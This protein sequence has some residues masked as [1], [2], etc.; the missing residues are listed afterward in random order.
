M[1]KQ[2]STD[3]PKGQIKG[4]SQQKL[5]G[6]RQNSKEVVDLRSLLIHCAQAVAADD[7]LLATDLIKK[8]RQHSSA[9]GDCTQRL[10]F[11][12][13]DGLEARLSGMGIQ[14]H[15]KLLAK[16]VSDEEVFKIYSLCLAAS[17]LLRASYCFANRT[18]IEASRGQ[19]KVHI[20]DFG[21][22]FGFQWPS[23]IQ[24]FAEQGVPPKLR[25][26]GID[27][28]RPGFSNLEITE[29]AG[30]RLADYANM[31]KVPFQYQGITS[32]YEN[33]QIEDIGIEEDEVLIVNSL[34]RMKTLGDETVAMNSARDRVLK[35]M[36]GM[37]P[38]VFI[39]GIVNGSYSSPFFITRFKELLFHYSSLFDMFDAN[40]PR[41][42]ETRKLI[43]GKLLGREAMNIIACEGAERIER[44][45]TYKQ[46]QARCLKA[47]F[48]QLPVDPDV[49]N[50]ILDMKKGI[51][52][53]DFV[54]DED[55]GWLLQGWK[56][57][58]MHAISKWKP[59]E[60]CAEQFSKAPSP[61]D[62]REYCD[63]NSN[64][65]LKYINRVLMEE[66]I[67]E[68]DIIYQEHDALQATEKPF[69]GIL[70]QAYPSSAKEMVLNNDS[71]VDCPYGS[72]NNN[73]EGACRGSFVNGFLG[74]QVMHLTANHCASETCHLSSQFTKRAEEA[75]RSSETC[76]LSSQFT[77]RAEEAN[78]SVP[79]IEKLV[80]DLDSSEVADSKQ[81]TQST[82][83]RKGKHVTQMMSHHELLDARNSNDLAIAG[84]EITRNG[85]FDN[86]LLC[87]GQ[88][89]RDAAHLRE[90]KAKERCD[91]SQ[92]NQSKGYGQGQ[93][94]K[95]A[96][97]QQEEAIDFRSLLIQCAEAI[98]ST[99]QPFDRE[100]LTKIRN[101]SSPNGDSSQRLAI[102]FVDA[103]EAR[104]AG[105][106]SQMYHKLIAKRRSAT[107]MLKAYRLCSAACPF[108]KRFA[109]REGSP[110]NLRITGIDVP[111]PGF[112]PSKKIEETGKRLAEYAE[113][114][115]I[116]FQYQ[117]VVSRW[118]NI[119]IEDLNIDKDEVL[120]INCLH[121]MKNLGDETED[122]DSAR[123][124]VLRIIKMMNP[125]VLIIGVT[126]GSY[127]SP[128]FL[129][130]FREV[131]FYYSSLFDMLNST[132]PRS[133][134]ARILIKKDI[135]GANVFNVVACEGA[136]RIEKPESY[137]KWQVRIFNAG[138][139]QLPV[140][141]TIL[142]S[143]I[144]RKELYHEDFVIDEDN[145]WLLQGWKGRVIHAL[146]S[147]KPKESYLN[148]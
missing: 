57:R 82:V 110:P 67:D 91:S 90:M 77:K 142:K 116:P 120:I 148:R 19:S 51:Y 128:F 79:I 97:K 4:S 9:D 26:T 12:L 135:I 42:N 99:N 84:C 132:V 123:D 106:G 50:S 125:D 89:Y 131:L 104:L 23:L 29:Q 103:L 115:N 126:N 74:P 41:D 117:V 14:M 112:H 122:I 21:I 17:P 66:D 64:I 25:I 118:E 45:E 145:G 43:E 24:Q 34:Y 85:S 134:E 147:W 139:R 35:I 92:N 70:G 95:R 107:D 33:I 129:P 146:S 138:F 93:V 58:V 94:K 7:R 39:L 27:V 22:C 80:V 15:H 5:R 59:N 69:Y 140:N 87:T 86:V 56:G 98:A 28:A 76:H 119:C 11:Y 137:K 73:L 78:R 102:Y 36:R 144:E 108:T 133:H 100:L 16:R 130:R 53:E 143:S 65:T 2:A 52:H 32:R 105:T 46:W 49:L 37:N 68:K 83:G 114:F 61:M 113:M 18:I 141:Q 8:I 6:K 96:K 40:V 72:S 38:K 30:K 20:V 136:E 81:M 121:Q 124:R 54:A 62:S 101:H 127:N 1:A 10:A 63:I 47:G 13:V 48:E 75:N 109:N 3:S 111:E 31:F 55:S 88:L 44:P 60:S 71:T